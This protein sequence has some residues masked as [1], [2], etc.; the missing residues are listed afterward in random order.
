MLTSVQLARFWSRV[1]VGAANA[2]WNW[3]GALFD[4]YGRCRFGKKSYGSHRLAYTLTFGEPAAELCV[5]HKCD[6]RRCCNP[7]HLF[8]GSRA[9]NAHDAMAKGRHSRGERHGCAKLT[10]AA[11]QELQR[12]TASGWSA[13]RL[14]RAF[15]VTPKTVRRALKVWICAGPRGRTEMPLRARGPEP[16]ASANSAR[17]ASKWDADFSRPGNDSR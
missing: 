7:A 2:C 12:L 17:P 8:L 6:N 14:A 5:L 13:A 3:Q 10:D 4:G 15:G 1:S 9:D 16:R 11:V